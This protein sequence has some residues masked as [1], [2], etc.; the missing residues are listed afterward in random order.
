MRVAM[1]HFEGKVLKKALEM[2]VSLRTGPVGNLGSP[3]TG[4]FKR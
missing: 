4:N 3:L 2:D 1:T